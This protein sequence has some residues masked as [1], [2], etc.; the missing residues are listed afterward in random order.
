MSQEP[1]R[2]SCPFKLTGSYVPPRF[3][4]GPLVTAMELGPLAFLAGSWR[5][6]G[7][8]AIW[9]PDNPDSRP[10]TNP[11]NQTK[12]FLELN[13][14]HDSFDF[15]VIPG[16]VPNR[17]LNPQTDLSLYGLHYL[18]RVSDA[19]P[20]PSSKVLPHGYSTTAG[21]ALHIEPG[22]FMNVPAAMAGTT[23]PGNA[24]TIVR[25]GSIP[26]GVTVLMQGPDPGVN[27][28]AGKPHI[29]PLRPFSTPGDIY[30]GLNP[31]PFPVTYPGT[32]VPLPLPTGTP[33]PPAVGIQPIELD[34]V[35]GPPAIK[36]GGQHQIPE[37][38]INAD[39][40]VP[41]QPP[42]PGP[43]PPPLPATSPY[44][45]QSSGPFPD[46]FQGF[47]DDPNSVLRDALDGQD[48]LGFIQI[49][50]TTDTQSLTGIPTLGVGSLFETVS[51]IPFLG[52]ANQTLNP[53]PSPLP[54]SPPYQPA[55]L[56]IE[57]GTT[58]N[59]FVYSASATFWIEWVHIP[60]YPVL[61]TDPG[62]AMKQLEPFWPQG[63]YLQLQYSQLV[64]L[65]FNN[66]LWPHV[67]VA[68]MT[69]SAG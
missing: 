58:P 12:R 25:M 60:D 64:I 10:L 68:T 41:H 18:Q 48:I 44:S 49:N 66:V 19:D 17:G 65:V 34:A 5:G 4:Q 46:T 67:T 61:K 20:A 56:A 55:T 35:T 30:P 24:P 50:L 3:Q 43:L 11:A 21:Q 62:P 6:P 32:N 63:S 45:Y 26:H 28:T 52:V 8:N 47:I 40:V 51:N 23:P 1:S 33:N 53:A 7:F 42:H 2:P 31:M 37:I 59:A 39:V 15:H 13:L 57:P 54:V 16:V 27:P 22:L 9:R 69:L 14:T 36:A 29:P 38:N